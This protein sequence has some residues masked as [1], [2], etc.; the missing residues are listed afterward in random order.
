DGMKEILTESEYRIGKRIA[1]GYTNKEIAEEL[2]YSY[3]YVKKVAYRIF[4]KLKIKKRTELR[5]FFTYQKD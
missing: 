2:S 5:E 1:L 4:E 3:G